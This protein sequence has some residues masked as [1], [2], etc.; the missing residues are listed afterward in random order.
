MTEEHA[1]VNAACDQLVVD[2][3]SDE[4]LVTTLDSRAIQAEDR[5]NALRQELGGQLRQEQLSNQ[6]I[7]EASVRK[8]QRTS[9]IE[10]FN[11]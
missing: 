6:R 1:R 10:S 3:R 9:L 2:R 4:T 11:A 8:I 7:I 5:S